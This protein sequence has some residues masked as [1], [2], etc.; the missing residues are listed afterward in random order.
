V[1][2]LRELAAVERARGRPKPARRAL[3]RAIAAAPRDRESAVAIV[4]VLRRD[5]G[6]AAAAAAAADAAVRR[7]AIASAFQT[8]P[9]HVAELEA[10]P[11]HDATE[12]RIAPL[13]LAHFDALRSETAA[14]LASGALTSE[15]VWDTEGLA[16]SGGCVRTPS[17]ARA[18]PR[19]AGSSL[20]TRCRRLV[21][22][23]R[24][25][26]SPAPFF[27][28]KESFRRALRDASCFAFRSR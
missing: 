14:L 20:F 7:G 2:T 13:L 28:W 5:L 3:R 4:N 25:S 26:S 19:R 24:A 18:A 1:A 10:K 27:L 8:P 12:L 6:D 15:S 21:C 23:R 17:R 16:T 22:A 11:F 9:H